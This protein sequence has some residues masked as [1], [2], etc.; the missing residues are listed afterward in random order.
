MMAYLTGQ[1]VQ[2]REQI[3]EFAETEVAPIAAEID[4]E[5]KF[6]VEVVSKMAARDLLGIPYPEKY[7][8][9]GL[10]TLSYILA[11]EELSRVCSNTAVTLVAHTSL[12]TYPIYRYGS[13]KQKKTYLPKMISGEWLGAFGLTEPNAGSDAGRVETTAVLEGDEWV[14]NG[15]K[16]FMTNGGRAGIIVLAAVTEPSAGA[17]GIS[18]F[19]VETDTPGCVPG[20]REVKMGWRGSDTRQVLFEDMRIP[21]KNLLGRKNRGYLQF[22]E[23]LD[24]GRISI[25]AMG[26]GVAEASFSACKKFVNEHQ[27]NGQK[28]KRFQRLSFPLADMKTRIEAARHL[29]YDAARRKDAGESYKTEAAMAK[30]YATELATW[31]ASRAVQVHGDFGYTAD[32]PVERFFRDAKILEIG[33]GTSEIQRLVIAR[34]VLR[35]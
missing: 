1:H 25:A 17:R 19:I 7:G 12:G 10:D 33:E 8:G 5:M 27:M 23:T 6:P 13:E 21:E 22:L 34:E 9:A 32:F 29:I 30:L 11:V 18:T 26:L 31:A 28:L 24:G 35:D 3:R 15:E 4:R 20:K 14:I 16:K 2:F